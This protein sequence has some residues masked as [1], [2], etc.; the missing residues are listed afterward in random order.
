MSQL[1]ISD[2]VQL[3]NAPALEEMAVADDIFYNGRF[4][5]NQALSWYNKMLL[6]EIDKLPPAESYHEIGGG[7]GLLPICLSLMGKRTVNIDHWPVRT[8]CGLRLIDRLKQSAPGLAERVTMVAGSFP[9]AMGDMDCSKAVAI[10]TDFAGTVATEPMEEPV[11]R[12]FLHDVKERYAGYIFDICLLGGNWREDG[13]WRDKLA[14]VTDIF[15][16]A[17]LLFYTK[18]EE[19]ARYYYVDFR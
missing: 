14:M 16:R 10:T 1:S 7:C 3:V 17:P 18:R 15:G 6:E 8:E 11:L 5:S 19:Y 12:Q 13:A 2:I 9:E 4:R